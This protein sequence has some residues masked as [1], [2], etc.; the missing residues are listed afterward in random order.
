MKIEMIQQFPIKF[1]SVNLIRWIHLVQ[2][3]D[4]WRALVNAVINLGVSL[5]AGKFLNGYTTD[6]H[7]STAQLHR[8]R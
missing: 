1:S 2:D 5:N 3:R 6:D 4:Q 8:V 7:S